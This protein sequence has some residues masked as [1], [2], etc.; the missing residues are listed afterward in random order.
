MKQVFYSD[1]T[2]KYYETEEE[3]L[4]E[5]EIVAGASAKREKALNEFNEARDELQKA[6]A[7]YNKAS[8]NLRRA[9]AE[10]SPVKAPTFDELINQLFSLPLTK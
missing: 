2:K 9:D 4:K 7:K 10:M 5:E 1:V 8:E 6:I 3:C